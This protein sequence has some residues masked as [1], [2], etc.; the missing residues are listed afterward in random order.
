MSTIDSNGLISAITFGRDI[1]LRIQQKDEQGNETQY[2]RK[3]L[4]VMAIIAVLLALSI[5]SVVQLWY[6][7]G[8]IIVPGILLP[9]L[10]TFTQTRLNNGKIIPAMILPVIVAIFWFLYGHFS[11]HYPM[12]IEPF[13]S[14]LFTSGVLV[15]INRPLHRT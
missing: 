13:Y 5:P 1:L 15:F 4:I 8:S 3:G 12:E 2:I 9:F 14:G 7:I 10:M 11:G 6:V